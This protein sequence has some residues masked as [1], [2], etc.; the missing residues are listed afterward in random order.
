[1]QTIK[2]N[3]VT[4]YS[5]LAA[6]I[7]FLA[8]L[9]AWAFY[10]GMVY[11]QSI[12]TDSI[13]TSLGVNG[14]QNGSGTQLTSRYTDPIYKWSVTVPKGWT[15]KT[16]AGAGTVTFQTIKTSPSGM[17]NAPQSAVPNAS[18]T[19]STRN[20]KQFI[21]V[22]TKAGNIIFDSARNALVD[23]SSAPY[24]CLPVRTSYQTKTTPPIFEFGGS[25]MSTPAHAELAIITSDGAMIMMNEQ[26]YEN[27]R[28][29]L[30]ELYATITMPKGVTAVLP[31]CTQVVQ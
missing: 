31:S 12:D 25:T 30:M 27:E 29:S 17:S 3:E 4:W 14:A 8:L 7:F 16:N 6:L 11:Q 20:T 2:M 5:K 15:Y 24:R 1:M 13:A 28:V 26:Q 21:P 10:I 22:G 23:S 19:F 18:V 9:P